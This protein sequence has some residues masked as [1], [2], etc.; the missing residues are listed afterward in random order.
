MIC[1]IKTSPKG[2]AACMWIEQQQSLSNAS[3]LLKIKRLITIII[4][5][6]PWFG[7][8]EDQR[9]R[10]TTH[11][12]EEP[13]S[14]ALG[15]GR[16]EFMSR[17]IVTVL[18]IGLESYGRKAGPNI[19]LTYVMALPI[20]RR[21]FRTFLKSLSHLQLWKDV[22]WMSL[23]YCKCSWTALSH[24]VVVYQRYIPGMMYTIHFTDFLN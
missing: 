13:L 3:L 8:A 20:D 7:D 18:F 19:E 10:I 4:I 2:R 6:S 9:V 22:Q 14:A 21:P 23:I 1:S 15:W 16:H 12:I 17:L 5:I 11:L 24:W